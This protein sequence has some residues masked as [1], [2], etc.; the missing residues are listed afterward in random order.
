MRKKC[1][2]TVINQFWGEYMFEIS[3][4]NWL[5]YLVRLTR[6]DIEKTKKNS[7][8]VISQL[9]EESSLVRVLSA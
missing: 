6:R 5:Q 3:K 2:T 1:I 8:N 4:L 9:I 7:S